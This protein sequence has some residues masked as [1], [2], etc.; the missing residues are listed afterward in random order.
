MGVLSRMHSSIVFLISEAKLRI[1]RT[2]FFQDAWDCKKE[3]AV[4]ARMT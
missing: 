1:E 2:L 4:K 3:Q